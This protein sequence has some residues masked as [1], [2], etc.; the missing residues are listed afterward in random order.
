[1]DESQYF[2]SNGILNGCWYTIGVPVL[3]MPTRTDTV[4]QLVV[5]DTS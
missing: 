5:H 3:K 4:V 1:M 2:D